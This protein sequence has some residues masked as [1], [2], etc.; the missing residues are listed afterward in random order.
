MN[1]FQSTD[2]KI[3]IKDLQDLD[4]RQKR[5]WFFGLDNEKDS[6]LSAVNSVHYCC[7]EL[8]KLEEK[9]TNMP[10]ILICVR[11]REQFVNGKKA[12]PRYGNSHTNVGIIRRNLSDLWDQSNRRK[13]KVSINL[14]TSSQ[15][16]PHPTVLIE[17]NNA[18]NA[19]AAPIFD[20]AQT[21]FQIF[22]L[23]PDSIPEY[24][25]DT[26]QYNHIHHHYDN[27]PYS[28]AMLIPRNSRQKEQQMSSSGSDN[29]KNSIIVMDE[30]EEPE[31][32]NSPL[33]TSKPQEKIADSPAVK[34]KSK[35]APFLNGT[36]S[37][38]SKDDIV[39]LCVEL[40]GRVLVTGD[41][42]LFTTFLQEVNRYTKNLVLFVDRLDRRQDETISADKL[43]DNNS[44]IVALDDNEPSV[45]EE[46]E[47]FEDDDTDIEGKTSK[48]DVRIVY[49]DKMDIALD[50][51]LQ[52]SQN[53]LSYF[54]HR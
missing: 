12:L 2:K 15:M 21:N 22:N 51:E 43:G 25:Q 41:S 24:E 17:D 5:I 7:S 6:V 52:H 26:F 1:L 20:Q 19:V 32:K 42:G 46:Q 11:S 50:E 45:I 8:Q 13:R 38:I 29:E 28:K 9:R 53:I 40:S 35:R 39:V 18:P 16:S 37:P 23:A 49:G 27:H 30:D 4:H 44:N 48:K 34:R 3:E 36:V 54:K 47:I 31:L 10:D 14:S 33:L